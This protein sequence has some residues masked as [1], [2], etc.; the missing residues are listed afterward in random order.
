[1]KLPVPS[2]MKE[3]KSVY[4]PIKTNY[5]EREQN[6]RLLG[7]GGEK[8][9]LNY[10]RSRLT[11][12]GKED[13]ADKIEWVSKELGDG[14][15]YD[16]LSKK[17]DGTDRYVEVKT[18]KL[19]KETPFYVTKNELSFAVDYAENFFFYRVYN[20]D[21]TPRLFIKQEVV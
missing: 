11:K 12:A 1:M 10:E 9:V 21:T 16:I 15:G 5:L 4:R 20:F 2:E 6:N 18:T 7:E 17:E 8:F 19:P 14:L 3:P 13:L